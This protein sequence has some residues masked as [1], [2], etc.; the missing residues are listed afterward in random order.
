[1]RARAHVFGQ[2]QV[3]Q[4]DVIAKENEEIGRFQV[5]VEVAELI[6]VVERF[7]HGPEITA[8]RQRI[9]HHLLPVEPLT[10]VAGMGFFEHIEQ[11]ATPEFPVGRQMPNCRLPAVV[12]DDEG[13]LLDLRIVVGGERLQFEADIVQRNRGQFEALAGLVTFDFPGLIEPA[14]P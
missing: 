13:V 5:A 8:T 6:E 4:L 7:G 2:S 14:S 11:G 1:M 9:A 12:S 3:A 10:A